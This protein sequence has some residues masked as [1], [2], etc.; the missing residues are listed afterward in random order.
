MTIKVLAGSAKERGVFLQQLV[1]RLLDELGYED[2]RGRVSGAGTELEMKA[3]HRA[4][5]AAILC[6]A[7]C[8]PREIGPD[9]LK[10]F[11]AA[12]TRE[13]KK[14]RR[15]VGLYLALSGLSRT[16]RD[17]YTA[18]EDRGKGEFH[19]FA[20]EKLLALFR[21]ARLI[22]PPELVEPA[23]K[24]RIRIDIG[25]RFLVYHEGHMYWVQMT[26]TGSKPTGYAVLASNGELVSRIV[27]RDIKRLDP[28]LEG[29]RLVDLFIRDKVFLTLLDLVPRNLEALTKE[30]RESAAGVREVLQD[31]TRENLVAIESGGQPRWKMDRYSLRC[32]LALFLSL[33]RQYLEGPNRF[34]FLGSAFTA[35]LFA[36]D[37]PTYLDARWKF[38]GL[39]RERAGLLRL[40]TL[41]P[42]ALNHA[43][44]TSTDRYFTPEAEPRPLGLVERERPR[45]LQFQRLLGDLLVRMA[46]DMEH[47]QFQELLTAK[48]LKAHLFRASVRGASTQEQGYDLQAESLT[49]IGRP[50]VTGRSSAS[51]REESEHSVDL[52]TALMHMREFEQAVAHF[53]RGIK[54]IKDP[55]R[56]LTAW[57]HRGICLVHL[58][59]FAEATDCFNE[60]LRF[61][62]N[63]SL[64]WLQKAVCL[65]ELGDV[66]GAQRCCRRAVEIDPQHTEA[67]DLL[68]IL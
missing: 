28:A 34:R 27:A 33:A 15:F 20:P 56:L 14:D 29:K 10:G 60:A 31:F 4:T 13:K 54:E 67:R 41:S 30:V 63:S 47:P 45:A 53:D 57:N 36:A 44:F 37:V 55:S 8:V 23:I 22:G 58:R 32:D 43:L 6:K 26:L 62:A 19:V 48:G 17:W 35:A 16:A 18:F 9:E 21:R 40:L 61:N 68:Q 3:K 46:S 52:G 5:Q 50:T 49:A 7:R 64:A 11:L 39:E 1:K 24:S 2:F 12:Y 42:G 65:K 59:K 25:Q 51:A 38:R 66:T